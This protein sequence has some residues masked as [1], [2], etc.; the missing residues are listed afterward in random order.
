MRSPLVLVPT[1]IEYET[2]YRRLA[3]V[4]EPAGGVIALC[5]FGVIAAAARTAELLAQYE[6]QQVVLVGIAGALDDR[7]SIGTA[8][9]FDEVVC[10]GIGSGSGASYRTAGEMGWLQ[11]DDHGTS[12]VGDML[13]LGPDAANAESP[14]LQ[15]LTACAA[16][17]T[18]AEVRWRKSKY[19][20]AAAE[21]ME[22]FSVAVACHLRKTP[23]QIIRGIAN[24]AGD[25]DPRNWRTNEA[26]HAAAELA[27]KVLCSD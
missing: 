4:V 2:L 9:A 22:G 12:D 15:L 19:P 18:P 6:P 5:G 7:L 3:A 24:R 1:R 14:P 16:S 8:C 13:P 26:L 27:S 11:W 23:L 10:Y 25:R 21:D 20:Q 17:A